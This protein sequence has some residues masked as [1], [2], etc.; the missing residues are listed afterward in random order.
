MV[1]S[2]YERRLKVFVSFSHAKQ[3]CGVAQGWMCGSGMD[4]GNGTSWHQ[5]S[6]VHSCVFNCLLWRHPAWAQCTQ[7][8]PGRRN[9]AVASSMH[10]HHTHWIKTISQTWA[11]GEF[12]HYFRMLITTWLCLVLCRSLA[13]FWGLSAHISNNMLLQTIW[14]LFLIF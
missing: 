12:L 5:E 7:L 9:P 2:S 3:R 10:L 13:D 8:S 14:L 4:I 1:I 6:P 11:R